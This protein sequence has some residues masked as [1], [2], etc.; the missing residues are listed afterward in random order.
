MKRGSIFKGMPLVFLSTGMIARA[1]IPVPP[2]APEVQLRSSADL[3][4]MLGPHCAL[5]GPVDSANPPGS[6]IAF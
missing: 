1:Q 6:N 3:D 2:P 5:P 4:Q